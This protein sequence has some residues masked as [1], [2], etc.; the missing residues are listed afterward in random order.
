MVIFLIPLGDDAYGPGVP[1]GWPPRFLL[2]SY[3]GWLVT[4]AW[5]A[6]K[7]RSHEA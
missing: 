6:I 3:M 4:L 7:V 5:Q 1:L 2:L